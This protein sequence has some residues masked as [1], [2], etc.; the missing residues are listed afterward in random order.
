MPL[1][2]IKQYIDWYREGDTTL[3]ERLE[4]FKRQKQNLEQQMAML[5]KHMEKINYKIAYYTEAATKGSVDQAQ[6][7]KNLAAER[8]RIFRRNK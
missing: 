3:P 2:G 4:M 1:K 8:E 5:N 7:N 6:K